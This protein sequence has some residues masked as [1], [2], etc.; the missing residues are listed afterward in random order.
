MPFAPHSPPPAPHRLH[1]AAVGEP[2]NEPPARRRG[3]TKPA[4]SPR[5]AWPGQLGR[6]HAAAGR[7]DPGDGG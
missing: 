4:P 3:P 1:R 5:Q 2:W 6:A 7:L